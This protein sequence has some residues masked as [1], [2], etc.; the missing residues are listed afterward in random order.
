MQAWGLVAPEAVRAVRHHHER[1]DGTGY[2]AR[3][4]GEAIPIEARY[5]AIADTYSTLTVARRGMPRLSRREA[6]REMAQST[7]Q[8]DPRV[9][10]A[11]IQ[12]LAAAAPSSEAA[13]A[14]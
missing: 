5:L 9:L 13:S 14:A 3:L 7:G 11:L 12:L 4:A 6:L 1:W 10:R 8:F 2:P